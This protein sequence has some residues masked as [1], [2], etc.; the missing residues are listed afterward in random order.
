LRERAERRCRLLR[1]GRGKRGRHRLDV[2]S[3]LHPRAHAV[4]RAPRLRRRGWMYECV[5]FPVPQPVR[6]PRAARLLTQVRRSLAACT[7][8]A[9][10]GHPHG[11]RNGATQRWQA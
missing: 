9:R 6:R 8:E 2:H 10:L 7:G 4:R 3:D 5:A 11:H 1:A